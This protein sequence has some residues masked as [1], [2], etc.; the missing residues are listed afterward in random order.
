MR[1]PIQVNSIEDKLKSIIQL[2]GPISVSKFMT[3]CLHDPENGYYATHPKIGKDFCTA[4]EISQIFG[5]LIGLWLVQEW[6]SMNCPNPFLLVELGPGR[7][8]LLSD[9][10]R[11]TRKY[12]DYMG[13]AQIYLVET[14][15]V[16]RELQFSALSDYSPHFLE[17]LDDLPPGPLLCIGNEFLDCLPARQFVY[18]NGVCH[19]RLVGLDDTGAFVFGISVEISGV[20]Y[21]SFDG[22]F[23]VQEG[24]QTLIDNFSEREEEF[25][26]LFFDYGTIHKVPGDTLRAYSVGLQTD[27]FTNLGRSDLTV[28]VDFGRLVRLARNSAI[29]VFGPITQRQFLL[30]LG[31]KTR[32]DV[33][34]KNNPNAAIA[35]EEGVRCL[36]DPKEMGEKFKVVCLS[37][38]SQSTPIGF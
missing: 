34:T 4:P 27:P 31:I 28:D 23:E 20:Q 8:T 15:P 30:G 26:V 1:E 37:S 18:K 32:L 6:H 7:G 21:D 10:L 3:V 9:A 2:N 13:A 16:L 19:E 29:D 35:I 36:I 12:E 38:D 17:S 25:R 11:V 5:E 14:S 33:L 22:I 24:L